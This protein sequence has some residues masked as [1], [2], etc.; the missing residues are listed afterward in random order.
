MQPTCCLQLWNVG[1]VFPPIP[2]WGSCSP[3]SLQTQGLTFASVHDSYW[4]HA[5]SIDQMSTIIRETFIALHSS[6]V[7]GRLLNEVTLSY[8]TATI[9][10]IIT[11]RVAFVCIF[12]VPRAI[13]GLQSPSCVLEDLPYTQTARYPRHGCRSNIS[14]YYQKYRRRLFRD[15]RGCDS[16]GDSKGEGSSSRKRKRRCAGG[17]CYVAF[18]N[19][20]GVGGLERASSA[21]FDTKP[22]RT[23]GGSSEAVQV[24]VQIQDCR[25]CGRQWGR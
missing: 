13:C 11:Q 1:Y 5:S 17:A 16:D 10:T 23:G 2:Q 15:H 25:D 8:P 4:T 12:L 9:L 24:R 7:L 18:A 6:D 20:V 3:S 19:G 14:S 21:T 22:Q